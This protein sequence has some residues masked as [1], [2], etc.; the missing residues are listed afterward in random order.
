MFPTLNV[1]GHGSHIRWVNGSSVNSND[2]LPALRC[3]SVLPYLDFK[4]ASTVASCT[5]HSKFDY[6]TR[7]ITVFQN[8][9][10]NFFSL[11]WLNG[12]EN[13]VFKRQ[14]SAPVPSAAPLVACSPTNYLQA[15]GHHIED[16]IYW[17]PG[18]AISPHPRLS[19]STHTTIVWRIVTADGAG[20]I[21]ESFQ[22]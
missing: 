11:T 7:S 18:L 12:C 4:T 10:S 16:M 13:F 2:P 20:V 1:M 22:R 15:G 19:T 3:I 8:S 21:G 5:V 14:A 6:C 9:N 17:H